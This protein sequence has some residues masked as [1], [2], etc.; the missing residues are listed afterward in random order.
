MAIS[1]IKLITDPAEIQQLYDFIRRFPLDYPNYDGWVQ[2]CYEELCLGTKKALVC[3]LEGVIIGNLIFQKH[4]RE[5]RVLELKNGRVEPQY[6]RRRIMSRFLKNIE[7]FARNNGD[8]NR[9]IADTHTGN[10]PVIKTLERA[11]FRIEAEE[12][13]YNQKQEVILI[14]DLT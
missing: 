9:I 2:Q 4:K 1:T 12:N 14:K 11:G 8:Y 5:P 10:L 3:K 6:R 13:L 7:E